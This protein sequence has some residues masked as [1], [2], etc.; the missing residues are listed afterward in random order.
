MAYLFSGLIE[1]LKGLLWQK[2]LEV[3]TTAFRSRYML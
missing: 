2:K 1:W 3:G